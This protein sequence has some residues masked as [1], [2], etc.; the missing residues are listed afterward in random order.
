MQM[1]I[2][3]QAPLPPAPNEHAFFPEVYLAVFH[4]RAVIGALDQNVHLMLNRV[5]SAVRHGEGI[6]AAVVI[7]TLDMFGAFPL[8]ITG[9]KIERKISRCE[10]SV[11]YEL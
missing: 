4:L 8:V 2:S 3:R 7:H 1:Q 9:D 10:I 11:Y 6:F 5:G